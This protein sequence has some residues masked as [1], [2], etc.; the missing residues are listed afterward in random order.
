MAVYKDFDRHKVFELGLFAGGFLV[1]LVRTA[2]DEG[3]ERRYWLGGANVGW[4]RI[5]GADIGVEG[6]IA[7]AMPFEFDKSEHGEAPHVETEA[8][9]RAPRRRGSQ[10]E[11]LLLLRLQA[12]GERHLPQ[13][14]PALRLGRSSPQL[15]LSV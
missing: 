1:A 4:T 3:E 11:V 2:A 12:E 9:S 10:G 14:E 5:N 15:P 7:A 13:L 8:A 6:H